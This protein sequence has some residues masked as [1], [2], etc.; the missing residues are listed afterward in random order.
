ME[1]IVLEEIIRNETE[2]VRLELT[3]Y[4]GEQVLCLRVYYSPDNGV[5]WRATRKGVNM[6]PSNWRKLLLSIAGV[7]ETE[8]DPSPLECGS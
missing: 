1:P 5:T 3:S 2:R 8:A 4:C 7:C 6:V